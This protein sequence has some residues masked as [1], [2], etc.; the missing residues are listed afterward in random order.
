[1]SFLKI[2]TTISPT[3]EDE[4][5]YK[6]ERSL[7]SVNS[8]YAEGVSTFS[9]HEGENAAWK[10]VRTHVDEDWSFVQRSECFAQYRQHNNQVCEELIY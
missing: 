6:D 9:M 2:G 5:V 7:V 3:T 10:A 4:I 8:S 1:M